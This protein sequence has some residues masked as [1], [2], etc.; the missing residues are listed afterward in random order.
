MFL[1]EFF[2]CFIV[3]PAEENYVWHI[4]FPNE[5]VDPITGDIMNIVTIFMWQCKLNTKKTN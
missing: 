2:I 1:P 5:I 4:F 3:L